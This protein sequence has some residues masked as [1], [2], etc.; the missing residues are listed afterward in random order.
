MLYGDKMAKKKRLT[1]AEAKKFKTAQRER[2]W[3]SV[4]IVRRIGKDVGRLNAVEMRK[5]GSG[6]TGEAV[7]TQR[8]L[9]S[10]IRSME[11]SVHKIRGLVK[12]EKKGL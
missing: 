2:A 10:E 1:G 7:D 8:D 12:K 6:G 11:N 4:R 3:D 9:R 5:L